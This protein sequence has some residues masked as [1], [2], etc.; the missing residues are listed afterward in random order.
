[1]RQAR[2][3]ATLRLEQRTLAPDRAWISTIVTAGPRWA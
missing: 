2:A 3:L 1:M